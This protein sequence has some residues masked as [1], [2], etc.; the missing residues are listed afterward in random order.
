MLSTLRRALAC[1]RRPPGSWSPRD[2]RADPFSRRDDKPTP[3]ATTHGR[4]P[5]IRIDAAGAEDADAVIAMAR[6]LADAVDDPPPSLDRRQ[7]V[8]VG[9]GASP[10]FECFIARDEHAPVGFVTA[11]RAF[12]AHTGRRRMWLGDLYV[13]REARGRGAG[14][15]LVARVARHALELGCDAIYWELWRPNS[16][17]QAFYHRL[18]AEAAEDLA[19]L[20][21]T[22]ARLAA[23]AEEPGDPEKR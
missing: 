22:G 9:F 19:I 6:E 15:A 23:L 3:T 4:Y 13:R 10:W 17:G 8:D 21:L 11:C 7:F 1:G 14:R 2:D 12:E 18:G 5:A 20:R 16:A